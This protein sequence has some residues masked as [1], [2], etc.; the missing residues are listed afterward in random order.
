MTDQLSLAKLQPLDL[1]GL[2]SD[3]LTEL[4]R[5]GVVRS[6]NN[7]A[8]DY[9]EYLVCQAL[10][11]TPAPRST[12]GFDAISEDG[13]K[14]EVKARRH[15]RR[16]RPTRFSAIRGLDEGHFDYLV[17]V[18]FE[19]RFLVHRGSV[20]PRDYVAQK[21]FWQEHVNGWILPIDDELWSAT[22]GLD[23]TEALRGVQGPG[24]AQ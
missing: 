17:A 4:F 13:S 12:K 23:I 3:T 1:L 8:A 9:A 15:T 19:E 2:Y 20:L 7:P 22:V 11:L 5:R 10:G 21:A 16:S 18:L 14:Y 24:P 6:V